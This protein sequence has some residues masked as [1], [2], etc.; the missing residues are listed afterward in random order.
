MCKAKLRRKNWA[1]QTAFQG[2]KSD[3]YAFCFCLIYHRLRIVVVDEVERFR[4]AAFY[5]AQGFASGSP[6]VYNS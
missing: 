1:E 2:R 4:M 3:V 5:P 6:E